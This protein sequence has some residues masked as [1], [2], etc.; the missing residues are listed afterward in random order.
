MSIYF[1]IS[2]LSLM[3]PLVQIFREI[4]I[5]RSNGGHLFIT[6]GINIT[7]YLMKRSVLSASVMNGDFNC[8]WIC[9]FMPLYLYFTAWVIHSQ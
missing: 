9:H 2:I 4:E 8:L 6:A 7:K 1:I 5:F 3:I